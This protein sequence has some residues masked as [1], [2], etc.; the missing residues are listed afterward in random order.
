MRKGVVLAGLLML[1][2]VVALGHYGV[3]GVHEGFSDKGTSGISIGMYVIGGMLALMGGIW[4]FVDA[5]DPTKEGFS[6]AALLVTLMGGGIIYAG[7]TLY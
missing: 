5:N 7:T 6:F 2:L 1:V 4:L 3:I